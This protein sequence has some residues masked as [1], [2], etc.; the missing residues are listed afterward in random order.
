MSYRRDVLGVAS[1]ASLTLLAEQPA[2]A[3]LKGFSGVRDT[4]D[5]YEFAYPFGWQ[6]VSVSGVD[7]VYKDIIEPLESLSVQLTP[8]I[9]QSITEYGPA[10]EIAGTLASSVL[11]KSTDEVQLIKSEAEQSEGR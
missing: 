10:N 3:K 4:G 7:S 6:E 11:A 9:K 5:G 2:L 1:G 8:T